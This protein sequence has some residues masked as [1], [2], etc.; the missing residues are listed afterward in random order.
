VMCFPESDCPF[1]PPDK[2][3]AANI[4]DD[5][6]AGLRNVRPIGDGVRIVAKWAST[7]GEAETLVERRRTGRRALRPR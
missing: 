1:Y 2:P 7:G 4:V 3:V 5:V 6:I